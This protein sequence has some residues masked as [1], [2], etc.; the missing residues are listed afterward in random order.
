MPA[1]LGV[2]ACAALDSGVGLAGAEPAVPDREV[3]VEVLNARTAPAW[4]TLIIGLTT[5]LAASF[6]LRKEPASL[7]RRKRDKRRRYEELMG[8][9]MRDVAAK[10]V[11]AEETQAV[12]SGDGHHTSVEGLPEASRVFAMLWDDTSEVRTTYYGIEADGPLVKFTEGL[13]RRVLAAELGEAIR[14]TRDALGTEV[15]ATCGEEAEYRSGEKLKE[16]L[17]FARDSVQRHLGKG[18]VDKALLLEA[19]RLLSSA[20]GGAQAKNL[21]VLGRLL[22]PVLPPL[23][24]AV[25]CC[26][27]AEALQS[28]YYQIGRWQL[29]GEAAV[30]Q[31]DEMVLY[32]L[33]DLGLGHL[34]IWFFE[35]VRDSFSGR[36]SAMFG[37]GVRSGVMEAILHQ[38]FEY[39]DRHS[40]GALQERLNRDAEELSNNFI[41]L[42][43]EILGKVACIIFTLIQ[44]AMVC[45]SDL[46]MLALSPLPVITFLHYRLQKFH[47][48]MEG[49]SRKLAEEA[50]ATTA[51]VLREIRTVRQFSNERHEAYGFA[52]RELL[53]NRSRE[54]S[55]L[56]SSLAGKL[57]G[58]IIVSGLLYT[59]YIGAGLVKSGKMTPGLLFDI[60]IKLNFWVVMRVTDLLN[61]FPRAWRAL[62]PLG[63]ICELL[64]SSPKIEESGTLLPLTLASRGALAA[65]LGTCESMTD[66]RSGRT[67]TV[68]REEVVLDGGATAPR[69]SVVAGF[70]CSGEERAMLGKRWLLEQPDLSFPVRLLLSSKRM[71]LRFEG[72]IEFDN[73][74]FRYPTDLRKEVLAGLSFSVRPREKVALVGEAGCGKSSCMGLLQ[75]LYD[76]LEGCIRID[77]IP[78][79]DYNVNFLRSRVV[80]VDQRP[81]LFATTVRENITYGLR[82]EVSDDE[83]IQVLRDASLWEGDNGIKSK[84]D[85][86][87]TRLGSGGVAL[88]GGQTQRVS[89]ARAMIR[90]PDVILL[91]EATSALDNKNEKIVQEALDRLAR[92]G[93]ALVIAHRLTTI[94]DADKIVV[95]RKGRMAEQGTHNELLSKPIVRETNE[96]G[97]PD[98]VEGIYRFL[99][100]LQFQT[101][102]DQQATGD[103]AAAED[104]T[105]D[106][107]S[108]PEN[109]QDA[110]A[111]AR[112]EPVAAGPADPLEAPGDLGAPPVLLRQ[113]RR[114][115]WEFASCGTTP[116]RS[117]DGEHDL[118]EAAL[119]PPPLVLKRGAT[120]P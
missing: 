119:A 109:K 51:E 46:F 15:S 5:L 103:P 87:L 114:C 39:F 34:L 89:I 80:I 63:R 11:A 32:H 18:F 107:E 67:T 37:Q 111:A 78:L 17:A 97:E 54:R 47:S 120:A 60:T 99:W 22:W 26:M 95:M 98:V 35:V 77:G 106:V 116:R 13:M 40:A 70:D 65:V 10:D 62:E 93:S 71:P 72:A 25:P 81:V 29:V 31:Q 88:S 84:P 74:V 115:P 66:D 19:D 3:G 61:L 28:I 4:I 69:G 73:V 96:E 14:K 113:L 76:P 6:L 104:P 56:A 108:K 57:F 45:P 90:N 55:T 7:A 83:V 58:V 24:V 36:A 59:E 16:K 79:Q 49:R 12:D 27:A 23:L 101:D 48:S 38:D 110:D 53:R 86:I 1:S 85:Q 68:L 64:R 44:V 82:R 43:Q 41:N 102:A 33:L 20:A 42:P 112:T 9:V 91:D 105:L 117:G 30:A 94:K 100:E 118:L 52:Q 92:R 50:A 8:M 75:R 2:A 21:H